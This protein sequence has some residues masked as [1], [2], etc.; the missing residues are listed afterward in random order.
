M[1]SPSRWETIHLQ[2]SARGLET[3]ESLGLRSL[4]PGLVSMAQGWARLSV[5]A[6]RIPSPRLWPGPFPVI[7]LPV[8]LQKPSDCSWSPSAR[9]YLWT[10][11][12]LITTG[13]FHN[14]CYGIIRT[15][16]E[17]GEGNEQVWGETAGAPTPP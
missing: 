11:R 9:E 7:H 17:E 5:G 12:T 3:Q 1:G 2:V 10:S 15:A 14:L 6:A 16:T 4:T 13:F 8:L